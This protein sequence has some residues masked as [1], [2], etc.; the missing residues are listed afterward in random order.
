MDSGTAPGLRHRG[1]T[2]TTLLSSP[3]LLLGQDRLTGTGRDMGTALGLTESED[4]EGRRP[5]TLPYAR[6][7]LSTWVCSYGIYSSVPRQLWGTHMQN[8]DWKQSTLQVSG[9]CDPLPWGGKAVTMTQTLH[10]S[11]N[12]LSFC[13]PHSTA[14]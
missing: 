14:S 12:P 8:C 2:M 3:S 7:S 13:E 4:L 10:T 5:H 6:H 1:R 9:K 11:M